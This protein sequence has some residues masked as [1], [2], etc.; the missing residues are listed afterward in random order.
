VQLFKIIYPI[1]INK[2]PYNWVPKWIKR[3]S[4][5]VKTLEEK[6]DDEMALKELCSK[7]MTAQRT[8]KYRA[9]KK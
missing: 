1:S 5:F 3:W 7:F 2:M 4:S 6:R 9:S 8:K